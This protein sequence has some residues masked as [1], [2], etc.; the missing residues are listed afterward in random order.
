MTRTSDKNLQNI[1]RSDSTPSLPTATFYFSGKACHLKRPGLKIRITGLRP[2]IRIEADV[3]KRILSLSIPSPAEI[4]HL[5]FRKGTVDVK[6]PGLSLSADTTQF[7]DMRLFPMCN[8]DLQIVIPI[9]QTKRITKPRAHRVPLQAS[10]THLEEAEVGGGAVII[11]GRGEPNTASQAIQK[12]D[13]PTGNKTDTSID[14]SGDLPSSAFAERASK[15]LISP[16]EIKATKEMDINEVY[17]L[18]KLRLGEL[19]DG[20]S[21]RVGDYPNDPLTALFI[22]RI[23]LYA[24][25]VAKVTIK[26]N[27]KK[28]DILED[29]VQ[30][31]TI[32]V[33]KNLHTFQGNSQFSTWTYRVVFNA[34]IAA[35]RQSQ[36]KV[37]TMRQSDFGGK[38]EGF[39][40]EKVISEHRRENNNHH[41]THPEGTEAKEAKNIL[42]KAISSLTPNH[43]AIIQLA[44]D[45]LQYEA[46]AGRLQIEL[47]TVRSRLNR[48]KLSLKK[49][50]ES[51]GATSIEDVM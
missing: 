1:S 14:D 35:A 23:R 43:R 26:G 34:C 31:A 22:E 33:L 11:S 50:L 5:Q 42:Q 49:A 10:K 44:M 36:R 51:F 25:A 6:L 38:D 4:E 29:A 12:S 7:S 17:E 47:N 20:C 32:Q 41:W 21:A 19:P 16:D 18:L 30:D 48:A 3:G 37:K 46:I 2:D 15:T 13:N 39:V 8:G 28:S 27:D 24:L 45:G 9:P 40:F